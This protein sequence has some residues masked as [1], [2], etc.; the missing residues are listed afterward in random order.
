MTTGEW[1]FI[2][3]GT[4]VVPAFVW[5]RGAHPFVTFS[6]MVLLLTIFDV[7]GAALFIGGGILLTHMR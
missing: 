6:G 7:K 3:L 2:W 5:S 1:L 4:A